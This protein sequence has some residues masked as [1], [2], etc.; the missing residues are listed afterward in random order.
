VDANGV[1][2]DMTYDALGR[3]RT[4]TYPDTG[5]ER[6]GYST[7]GLV[8][9]TN[10]LGLTNF[11]L[12]D[13]ASRKIAETNANWEITQFNYD[14]S[15]SLT[16]LVDGKGQNTFWNYDQFGRVTNKVDDL[17][18][19]LLH[20]AYDAD[21]R[22]TNRWSI[23]KGTTTYRYDAAGNLTNVVY[24]VSPAIALAYDAMN[25]LTNMVDGIGTTHY[26]LDAAGQILSEDGP[27]ADDTVSYAYQ[28]RLRTSLSLLQPNTSPWQQ[29]YAYDLAR[30]LT[31]TT[32]PAGAFTYAYD[33][34]RHLQVGRLTLPSGAYIANSYDDTSR[35]LSTELKNTSGGTLNSHAYSYNLAN[36]RTQQ[37]FTDGNYINYTYDNIGQLRSAKG[38]ESDTTTD[39]RQEQ[40]GYS[41]S[42]W[43]S[44]NAQAEAWTGVDKSGSLKT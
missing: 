11:Y 40:F 24:P 36:Q 44:T 39:R 28:N 26:T 17:S 5:V 20:Y 2:L 16:N 3:L 43:A 33:N 1:S 29:T 7:N 18:N 15:G 30:R 31:N 8:A 34:D 25:R 21:N 6:F 19:I 4:R 32:S 37:V 41:V 13:V 42:V 14:S 22:L 12:N 35:L 27:W 9:Y 10:Q 23:A 38:R